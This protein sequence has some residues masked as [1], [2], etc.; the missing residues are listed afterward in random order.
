MSLTSGLISVNGGGKQAPVKKNDLTG[1]LISLGGG[2]GRRKAADD[3][4]FGD[5]DVDDLLLDDVDSGKTKSKGGKSASPTSKSS[6][7]KKKKKS[8]GSSSSSSK[9]KKDKDKSK[10]SLSFL[11]DEDSTEIVVPVKKNARLDDEFARMLGLEEDTAVLSSVVSNDDDMK[12]DVEDDTPMSPPSY[13]FSRTKES[14]KDAFSAFSNGDRSPKAT[15]EEDTKDA[16]DEN[17]GGGL[18]AAFFK[19]DNEPVR[20][21]GAAATGDNDF[22]SFL[23]SPS[24]NGRRGGRGGGRRGGGGAADVDPL[25]SLGGGGESKP[26]SGLDDLFSSKPSRSSPFSE[27]EQAYEKPTPNPQEHQPQRSTFDTLFGSKRREDPPPST[28]SAVEKKETSVGNDLLAELFPEQSSKKAQPSRDVTS[29]S[30]SRQNRDEAQQ[31]DDLLA[32]LF[33]GE[34]LKLPTKKETPPRVDKDPIPSYSRPPRH[35]NKEEPRSDALKRPSYEAVSEP[36]PVKAS[37][38]VAAAPTASQANTGDARDSLLKDLLGDEPS[39]LSPSPPR[40]RRRATSNANSTGSPSPTPAP[41]PAPVPEPESPVVASVVEAQVSGRRKSPVSSPQPRTSSPAITPLKVAAASIQET[42]QSPVEQPSPGKTKTLVVGTPSK[43][44][45][46]A[47]E[48]AKDELLEEILSSTPAQSPVGKTVTESRQ[49]P[50][51]SRRNSYSLWF[52]NEVESNSPI[53]PRRRS[54]SRSPLRPSAVDE[55]SNTSN[56]MVRTPPD[57][58]VVMVRDTNAEEELRRAHTNEL[59]TIRNQ[60]EGAVA[61]LRLTIETLEKELESKRERIEALATEGS[62]HR[63]ASQRMQ[64]ENQALLD[65]LTALQR[66]HAEL[67]TEHQTLETQYA[68]QNT[69]ASLWTREKDGFL[70]QIQSVEAQQRA[71]REELMRSKQDHQTTQL[72][73][74][75]YKNEKEHEAHLQS[76]KE[77]QHMDQLYHQLQRSLVHLQMLQDQ[78]TYDDTIKRDVEDATRMRMLTSLEASSRSYAQQTESECHRLGSLLSTLETTLRHFR[79]EHLEEKERLRQ[80]QMRLNALSAHFQAQSHVLHEQ[81]DNNTQLLSSYLQSSLQDVRMAESRLVTRRQALEKQEKQ[82]FEDRASFAALREAWL[83]QRTQEQAELDQQ[84]TQLAREWRSL[85][86]ERDDLDTVVAEHEDAFRELNEMQQALEDEKIRL[87]MW[88]RKIAEMAQRC[89]TATQQIVAKENEMARERTANAS[90]EQQWQQREESVTAAQRKLDE[91]EGRLLAQ[92][93]QMELA[94]R[95]LMEER[96]VQ[97]QARCQQKDR[98]FVVNTPVLPTKSDHVHKATSVSNALA[99][100]LHIS[101]KP[102]SSSLLTGFTGRTTTL[103]VAS[104]SNFAPKTA[105]SQAMESLAPPVWQD[106]SGLS[107]AFRQMIEENWQRQQWDLGIADAALQKERMWINCIGIDTS[108]PKYQEHKTGGSLV[109]TRDQTA[110]SIKPKPASSIRPPPGSSMRSGVSV[111][112]SPRVSVNL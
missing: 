81:S 47:F 6:S 43:A 97:L 55:D 66:Q 60:H 72:Q 74:S 21:R 27:P 33:A 90:R 77:R 1:G 10:S 34:P 45:E 50:P 102:V 76:H 67:R 99:G 2:G 31:Q 41:A 93:Q 8:S 65:Q 101:S 100:S 70:Q 87:G 89:E 39:I 40:S 4:D 53:R 13:S 25:G 104:Q 96:K 16:D 79:Q 36:P 38:Q 12:E 78:V 29:T 46:V 112:S 5:F 94:R 98:S 103:G 71:L 88:A 23:S 68:L 91:R 73:F 106:P 54:S 83:E 107:P 37:S 69:Q 30:A 35:A 42:P 11:D 110:T 19:D 18:S 58:Q 59:A 85:E 51:S 75:Q 95:R 109:A 64:L 80:E 26:K 63:T 86:H 82:L 9:K 7:Y 15:Q 24:T 17:G 49:S 61:Q 3:D 108:A 22:L 111:S 62:T 48:Q 52:D 28:K 14:D 56:A 57:P 105:V 92:R 20:P 32:E 44:R 84:R